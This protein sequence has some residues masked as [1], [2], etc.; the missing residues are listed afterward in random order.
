[1]GG[2][3]RE[4][5]EEVNKCIHIVGSLCRIAETNIPL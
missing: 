3:G 2:G 5:Q 1:M 4:V